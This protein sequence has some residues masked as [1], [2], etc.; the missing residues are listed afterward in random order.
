[1]AYNE[2][3]ITVVDVSRGANGAWKAPTQISKLGYTGS[4][5]THQGWF[6]ESQTFAYMNDEL[7]EGGSSRTK[8]YIINMT[9]LSSPSV[10]SI[11]LGPTTATDH[12]EYVV[13]DRLYQANYVAGL[14]ILQ[15]QPD[16]GLEEI[17]YFVT[18]SAWSVYPYFPSGNI[19]VSSIP[20]GL[21]VLK[22]YSGPPTPAPPPPGTWEV[23][24]S[25]CAIVG[26]CVQS[27]NHPS[28][29]GNNEACTVTVN[30]VPL[31]TQAFST[32]SGYDYLFANGVGYSGSSR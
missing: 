14:R 13:G 10:Y 1:M 28:N 23:S 9:S 5:Y 3:T 15:I 17:A 24:G 19:V 6:D 20:G 11:Y 31:T 25:G 29:Y 26:N 12:N 7:D 8:S 27:R 22:A 16:F 2:D 18:P 4:A 21:F 30:N 32:E